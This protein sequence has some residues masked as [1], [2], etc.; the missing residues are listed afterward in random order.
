MPCPF[1]SRPK[2]SQEP[3]SHFVKELMAGWSVHWYANLDEAQQAWRSLPAS[4]NLFLSADYFQLLNRL[5][6]QGVTTGLAVFHGPEQ[7]MIGAVVQQFS[8]EPV[9]QIGS[10]QDG[11][12]PILSWSGRLKAWLRRLVG[13]LLETRVLTL[14]QMHL[15]GHHGVRGFSQAELKDQYL[16]MIVRGLEAIAAQWPER[17]HA[18]MLKDVNLEDQPADLKFH[19]LPVQPTMKLHLAK[20]WTTFADYLGAMKS[21]YRVRAR[22]SRKKGSEL[23]RR[24][25]TL[26]EIQQHQRRIYD[27][28]LSVAEYSD[29]NAVQLPE[30]Y[31]YQW[32][33]QFAG[34]FRLWGYFHEGEMVGFATAIYNGDE[35]EAHFLGFE[36]DVNRATQLYLNML[37]DLVDCGIE[38]EAAEVIFAR[39][40][41]EIKSSVGAVPERLDCWLRSRI[42]VVNPLIPIVTPFLYPKDEWQP[43]HPFG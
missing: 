32:K 3:S 12:Q 4:S 8:F 24:E 36:P 38:A 11:A 43:R 42:G 20:E 39:T 23:E 34:R 6:L 25:L 10:L 28:Y 27:L 35:L 13:G 16:P 30:D 7:E 15:T 2:I 29:Y 40:A 37:Y 41:L 31:F 9:S 17:I 5:A 26:S 19:P 1:S 18:L 22:R 14:G 21:K 33:A